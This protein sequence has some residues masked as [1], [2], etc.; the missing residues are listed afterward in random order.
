MLRD[1]S[2]ITELHRAAAKGGLWSKRILEREPAKLVLRERMGADSQENFL[3]LELVDALKKNGCHVFTRR[4][5]QVFTN[6]AGAGAAAEGTRLLC[7]RRVLGRTVVEPITNHSELL[8]SFN[9]PIDVRHTY[10]LRGDAD[11]AKAVMDQLHVW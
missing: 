4:S 2:I 10:V 5:R 11:K 8:A 1:D 6:L 9:K 3:A 7:T